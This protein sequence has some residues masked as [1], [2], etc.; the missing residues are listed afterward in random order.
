[1]ST[2]DCHLIVIRHFRCNSCAPSARIAAPRQGRRG[3]P[4]RDASPPLRNRRP[5]T[6]PHPPAWLLLLLPP[7]LFWSCQ[8][9]AVCYMAD[10]QCHRMQG[11]VFPIRGSPRPH[12]GA[13]LPAPPG[14]WRP[15]VWWGHQGDG[16]RQRSRGRWRRR[17][18]AARL[19][20]PLCLAEYASVTAARTPGVT[21]QDL[22]RSASWLGN[23][24]RL[25]G[26][27]RAVVAGM[28]PKAHHR[29]RGWREHL[30]RPW[31]GAGGCVVGWMI[32]RE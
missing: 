30:A 8:A 25:A 15:T 1:L 18:F 11:E 21:D 28:P 16:A 4:H 19:P 17:R 9:M 20:P 10:D 26:M 23:S 3:W 32:G 29:G 6:L 2:F 31:Q 5:R 24:R 22:R 12:P 27:I 14:T 7:A 13:R